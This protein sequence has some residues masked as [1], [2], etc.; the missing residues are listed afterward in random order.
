MKAMMAGIFLASAVL[1]GFLPAAAE[2]LAGSDKQIISIADPILDNIL[3]GFRENDYG[4]YSRDL[5]DMVKE[6]VTEERFPKVSGQ[7]RQQV[8]V[9]RSRQYLGSLRKGAMTV[10]LWKGS[11]DGTPDDVLIKLTLSRRGDRTLVTGLWFQ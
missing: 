6:S 10:V 7:I 9:Y 11:F 2:P 3:A 8:G 5:D 4:R 1:L